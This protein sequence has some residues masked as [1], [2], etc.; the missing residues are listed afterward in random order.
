MAMSE[1]LYEQ[2]HLDYK[3]RINLGSYYTKPDIVSIAYEL[4]RKRIEN[5]ND[6]HILDTSCGYGSFFT[7]QGL[8]KLKIGAD[9]DLEAIQKAKTYFS[10]V[11]FFHQNALCNAN[12]KSYGIS[13]KDK[14]IIVGNPPYNDMTSIIR[15]NIKNNVSETIDADLKTRDLGM[16]FILSYAKLSADFICILHPL[17]YLI[18][19]SNFLLLKNFTKRYKLI[20]SIIIGSNQFLQTSKSMQFP[21]IIALYKKDAFG[22]D[23]KF[24]ENYDFMTL[25]NK[26]FKISVFDSIANYVAK[27]PNSRFVKP[28]DVIAKFWTIRDINALRRNR[29]FIDEASVNTIFVTME[30]LDYYCYIDVFKRY[31]SHI[32]YYLG[33][34][35][36]MINDLDFSQIR[37]SFRFAS[38][39]NNPSLSA[40]IKVPKINGYEGRIDRYFKSLL[41][42]HYID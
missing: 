1:S 42:E 15:N 5:F 26:T 30:K 14:V 17:S 10:D 38:L 32:P 39:Q 22:M 28:K 13:D 9:I 3:K 18:K 37:E 34:C 40:K 35:D 36:I 11:K 8:S 2:S 16:S 23:Y 29:T 12:R 25:E 4:I 20:D 19:K 21:I 6:Y 24:I 31:A 41:K 27:Y 33:N 7:E